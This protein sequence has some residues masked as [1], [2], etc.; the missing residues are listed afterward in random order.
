MKKTE[1]LIE[2]L[3]SEMNRVRELIKEYE[4]LPG[5]VGF[6]GSSIMK[7]K[8]QQAEKAISEGDVIKELQAYE[9]LKD[10]TG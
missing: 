1:N 9:E 8:I 3:L 5:G 10:C 4:D 6:F 2:G 7:V